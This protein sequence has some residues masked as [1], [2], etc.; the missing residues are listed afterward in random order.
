M[1]KMTPPEKLLP[2]F[3]CT[4][5]LEMLWKYSSNYFWSQTFFGWEIV[6]SHLS[7]I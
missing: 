1:H 5:Y 4:T 3:D 7:K 2:Q 6:P